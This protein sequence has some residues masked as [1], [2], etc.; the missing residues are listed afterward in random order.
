MIFTIVASVSYAITIIIK[1]TKVENIW[2]VVYAVISAVSIPIGV[3]A[4]I[5]DAIAISISLTAISD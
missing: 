4:A 2:A 1:L 5:T 3:F